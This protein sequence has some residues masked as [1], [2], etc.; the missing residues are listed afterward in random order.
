MT[1][2]R[3]RWANLNS[4]GHY[5][6]IEWLLNGHFTEKSWLKGNLQKHEMNPGSLLL[7]DQHHE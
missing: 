7:V 4:L 5:S 6:D 3:F 2:I 1:E